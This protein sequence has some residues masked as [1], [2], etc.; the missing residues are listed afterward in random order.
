[1]TKK[2]TIYTISDSIGETSQKLLSAV[3]AQ[4]PDLEVANNYRFP[5]VNSEEHLLSILRDAVHDK[6]IVVSTLVNAEL[7]QA[8]RHFAQ[9]TSIS[10]IDLMHPF[11]EAIHSKTGIDP[12]QKPGTVHTLN[13]DYF[14]RISAIEFAVKYDDG[15]DPHGFIDADVVLLGISRTSKTPLSMYLANKAIKAANL[16]LIPEVPV[17]E[18]IA[19]LPK[20]KMFG[21]TCAPEA[22]V[23]IRQNRLQALGLNQDANYCDIDRI[24]AEIKYAND[25]FEKLGI[26]V[27]DVTEKSIEE[28]AFTIMDQL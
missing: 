25:L 27:L 14:N 12:I 15:K 10:Y 3:L 20:E 13:S 17:P 21:L 4:Y 19:T 6:A 24:K 18:I 7:A 16:P 23:K 2:V 5:F 22:L 11:F 1:M 9:R 26:P 8:A 28:T